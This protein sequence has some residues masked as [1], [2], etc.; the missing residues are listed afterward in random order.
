MQEQVM[1]FGQGTDAAI[2]FRLGWCP[3]K[4]VVEGSAGLDQM[5]WTIDML[6]AT[7]LEYYATDGVRTAETDT[8]ITLVKFINDAADLPTAAPAAVEPGR[9]WEANGIMIQAGSEINNDGEPFT[10]HCFR[11]NNPIIRAV[12]D[13]T[14]NNG[15]YFEDSSIDFLEA[16]VSPNGKFILLNESNDNYAYVGAITKPAGKSNHC[17][18]YTYEDENLVTATAAADFDTSDVIFIIPRLY[19]QYPLSG[20]GLMT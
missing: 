5:V 15:T 14:T 4:V 13:G 9:Y 11:M 12:H 20:I 3:A 1:V 8:G 6:A 10:A 19:V 2:Y 17:R 7:G 18:I 16:G